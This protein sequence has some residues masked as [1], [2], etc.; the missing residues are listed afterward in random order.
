M[1]APQLPFR[2]DEP[3]T[4][5]RL[6][7]RLM[8]PAD[9]DDVHA[10][11][12]RADVARYQLFD[13]RTRDEVAAKLIEYAAAT[14]LAQ[15][16]DFLQ[17]A[18]ELPGSADTRPRVIGD[19]FFHLTSVE[20]SRAEI[21]WTLHPDSMGR[22]YATE[23]AEAVLDLAFVRLGL[24][25]VYA[26]LDPR[27]DPSIRLCRRLGMREEA[28]FVGDLWFKGGWADTGAYA[29]LDH[30]WRARTGRARPST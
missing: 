27:N 10:Y 11:Q 9:V 12:S 15:D 6:V 3:I 26:E 14:T 17:L 22:G 28:Y 18:L 23:A 7:L 24:H 4:T 1:D 19:S 2:F 5:E 16:G 13:P 30:E 20:N 21:G 25:R 8:T 29:I